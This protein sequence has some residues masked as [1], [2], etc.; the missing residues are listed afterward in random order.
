MPCV[1][2][3]QL[4]QHPPAAEAEVPVKDGWPCMF[5]ESDSGSRLLSD[6]A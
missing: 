1:A 5:D 3:A 6:D 4:Q 2:C